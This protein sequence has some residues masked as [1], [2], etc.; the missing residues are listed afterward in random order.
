MA[1]EVVVAHCGPGLCS[2]RGD[3]SVDCVTDCGGGCGDREIRNGSEIG[4]PG[5]GF[6]C[7]GLDHLDHD[8]GCGYGNEMKIESA[9]YELESDSGRRILLEDCD[10]GCGCDCGCG[11]D[12]GRAIDCR[13]YSD[14]HFERVQSI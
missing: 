10:Y 7:D 5:C 12:L 4:G 3:F 13:E 1:S 9:F 8:H 2:D 14:F 6:C 11:D